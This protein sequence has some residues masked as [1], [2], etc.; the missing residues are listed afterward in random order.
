[1]RYEVIREIF[2]DCS[3]NQMRDV[4]VSTIETDDIDH[5]MDQYRS[6]KDIQEERIEEADG[7]IVYYLVTDGIRQRISFSEDN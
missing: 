7:S 2:N 1:M 5:F 6:G 4:S 3:N